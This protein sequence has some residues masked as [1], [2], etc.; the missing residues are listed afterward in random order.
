MVNVSSTTVYSCAR[1]NESARTKE[2]G[3]ENGALAE[4]RGLCDFSSGDRKDERLVNGS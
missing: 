4:G 2:R 1:P 3:G